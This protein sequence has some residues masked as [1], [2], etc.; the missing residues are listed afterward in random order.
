[1]NGK[2]SWEPSTAEMSGERDANASVF[3]FV[4][5]RTRLTMES[6]AATSGGACALT[7]HTQR[8]AIRRVGNRKALES[9]VPNRATMS[10]ANAWMILWMKKLAGALVEGS[11]SREKGDGHEP[12]DKTHRG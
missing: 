9:L 6:E 11:Q 2:A 7:K 4:V 12:Q 5:S 8:A 3:G 10:A 1:M